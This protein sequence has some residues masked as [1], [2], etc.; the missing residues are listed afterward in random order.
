MNDIER[1]KK[2]LPQACLVV[3]REESLDE[4][5][6]VLQEVALRHEERS[7]CARGGVW[8]RG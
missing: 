5:H 4:D 2:Y 6:S 7:R 1:E 3:R 8:G